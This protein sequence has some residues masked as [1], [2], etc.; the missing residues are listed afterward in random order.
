MHPP[1]I[2]LEGPDGSGTTRHTELLTERLQNEGK[3]VFRTAEPTG[4]PIGTFIRAELSKGELPAE[5]LQL[6]F[7]ADRADHLLREVLPALD[8][9]DTVVC[10]RYIPSTLAYGQA[11]G[12]PLEWLQ[13]MNDHFIAA[14]CM[15]FALPPF[16]VCQERLA[17]REMRDH[18][19]HSER[20]RAVYDE[21]ARMAELDP[22]I[23]VIDTSGEKADVHEKIWQIVAPLLLS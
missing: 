16:E 19:E 13:Q 8:R 4:G 10:D 7:T 17:R 12:L 2:V 3:P 6:L 11:L 9:G 5:S 20:Q 14:D 22:S 18:L 15:I 23:H 21:Y 1:F